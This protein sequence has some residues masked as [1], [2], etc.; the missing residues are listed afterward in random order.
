MKKNFPPYI[1]LYL[2][3]LLLNQNFSQIKKIIKKFWIDKPSSSL[4]NVI[5]EVLK[6]NNLNDI[7]FIKSLVDKNISLLRF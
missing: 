6:N 7:D 2:E 3:I 5:T 1:K 4:R